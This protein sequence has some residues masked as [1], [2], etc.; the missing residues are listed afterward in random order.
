[1]TARRRSVIST[2]LFVVAGIVTFTLGLGQFR[3][4]GRADAQTALALDAGVGFGSD[5]PSVATAGR[6]DASPAAESDAS[7][8]V[9]AKLWNGG[10]I[11]GAA[12]IVLF[13]ALSVLA[14][15]DP[16]HAFY[17]TAGLTAVGLVVT[18]IAAGQ[19]PNLGTMSTV[20][21]AFVGIIARGPGSGP[22]PSPAPA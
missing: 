11:I 18:S 19:T 20:A 6:T 10:Q 22:P 21:I 8:A 3:E 17:W 2:A 7:P 15:V 9:A 1:M 12:A 5:A 4:M 13:L 16:K 14:K